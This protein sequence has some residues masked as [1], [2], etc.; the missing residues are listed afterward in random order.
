VSRFVTVMLSVK[1]CFTFTSS[2]QFVE[3]N[4]SDLSCSTTKRDQ[5]RNNKFGHPKAG[6]KH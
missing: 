1:Y 3:K 4:K 2:G 5:I 6:A